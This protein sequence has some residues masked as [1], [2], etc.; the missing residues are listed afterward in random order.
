MINK[1]IFLSFF[2]FL[3]LMILTS[4][5]KNKTR[6]IEKNIIKHEKKIANLKNDLLESQLDYY[7]LT[8][9]N[10][11]SNKIK[12]NSDQVYIPMDYS[13]IYMSLAD[14]LKEQ[15]KTT[16]NYLNEN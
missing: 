12:E 5:V 16:K 10:Y 6:L 14:F 4:V 7:Y 8:S 2:I 13:K 15:N 9:P 1:K 3:F 11:I